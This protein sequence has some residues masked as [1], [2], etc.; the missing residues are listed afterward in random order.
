[1]IAYGGGGGSSREGL[2]DVC[3]AYEE[4]NLLSART[5]KEDMKIRPWSCVRSVEYFHGRKK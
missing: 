5:K 1:M 3:F 4:L 2:H